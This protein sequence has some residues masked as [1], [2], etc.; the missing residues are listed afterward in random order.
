MC[1]QRMNMSISVNCFSLR[2]LSFSQ[3]RTWHSSE[4]FWTKAPSKMLPASLKIDFSTVYPSLWHQTGNTFTCGGGGETKITFFG[5]SIAEK[6]REN[7]KFMSGKVFSYCFVCGV[8]GSF[9]KRSWKWFQRGLTQRLTNNF[10]KRFLREQKRTKDRW[11]G[12]DNTEQD[13]KTWNFREDNLIKACS[14]RGSV[15]H[16]SFWV[17]W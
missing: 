8:E 2:F 9:F 12:G 5:G 10:L 4:A 14:Y 7:E 11:N 17:F 6:R 16:S 13:E 15:L 1:S 3:R